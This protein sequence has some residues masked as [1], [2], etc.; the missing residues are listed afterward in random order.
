MLRGGYVR[1]EAPMCS[2]S[3]CVGSRAWY[4]EITAW[5]EERNLLPLFTFRRWKGVQLEEEWMWRLRR[6]V[7]IV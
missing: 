7:D 1:K 4:Q 6:R 3:Q 2:A 5:H